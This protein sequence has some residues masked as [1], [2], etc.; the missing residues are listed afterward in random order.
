MFCRFEF[1]H[2]LLAQSGGLMRVLSTIVEPFVLP[3]FYAWQEFTFRRPIT[4][5]FISDD[6]A[7][8]I[9]RVSGQ[10]R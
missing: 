7:R 8:N 6:D 4:L 9:F 1:T 10:R 2:F 5:Q 3:M